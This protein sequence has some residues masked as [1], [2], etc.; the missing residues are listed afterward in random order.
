MEGHDLLAII[1]YLA[2]NELIACDSFLKYKLW[3]I[4]KA[5]LIVVRIAIH[6]ES[7]PAV[8]ARQVTSSNQTMDVS[9]S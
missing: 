2:L 1:W 3:A 6:H 4:T 7:E 5:I 8:S 9:A